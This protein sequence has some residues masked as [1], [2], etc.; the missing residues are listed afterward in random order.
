MATASR[1]CHGRPMSRDFTIDDPDLQHLLQRRQDGIVSRDQ[2]L[3]LG[4][5]ANDVRRLLRRRELVLRHPGVYSAHSGRL[6]RAELEWVAVLAA[7]PAALAFESALPE[8]GGRAIQV[9][10]ARGRTIQPPP[11]VVVTRMNDLRERVDW[12]AAPPRVRLEHATLDTME[13][14]LGAGDVAA[15][16]STLSIVLHSRRISV[17]ELEEA[18]RARSRFA[19]RAI[20][21]GL[22]DDARTGACS[23]LER[24][25]LRW[26]ERAHGLPRGTRQ[27]PSRSTGRTTAP[28]V[29]YDEYGLIV[30]L[31]GRAFHDSPHARDADA[32]RDLAELAVRDDA[33]ARVTYG[34]VFRDG[35]RTAA[36][37]ATILTRRG[38]QGRP[39]RCPR[40]PRTMP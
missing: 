37:I 32:A 1:P 16:F 6:T 33:T 29:R 34:L 15:A 31:D 26:V 14:A 24:G 20:A 39:H 40:C 12:R 5:K 36:R 27:C 19:G 2:L 35:C 18:L 13:R 4:A 38:W 9:V 30:E 28:D 11:G 23:V 8:H 17:D 7:W 22:L 21:T 10:V 25:Y 3:G